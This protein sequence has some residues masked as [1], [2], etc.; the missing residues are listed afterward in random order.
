M[1]SVF[2]DSAELTPVGY[3][4]VRHTERFRVV[5]AAE[6]IISMLQ[7]SSRAQL[8]LLLRPASLLA[9]LFEDVYIRACAG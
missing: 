6:L 2:F 3:G 4:H 1:R 8:V 7:S 9:L 5:R